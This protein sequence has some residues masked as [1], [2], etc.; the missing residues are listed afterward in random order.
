MASLRPTDASRR[1]WALQVVT[2]DGRRRTV[3]LALSELAAM[4]FKALLEALVCAADTGTELAPET[5]TQVGRLSEA[6][7]ARLADWGLLAEPKAVA[8]GDF[9]ADY[10]QRRRADAKPGTITVFGHTK[11]CLITCFGEN[12]PIRSLTAADGEDFRH[13]LQTV[14]GLAANTVNRRCGIA[15][16]FFHA[17]KRRG[18]VN[19]NPFAGLPT[20]VHRNPA[21]DR[22]ITPA[23]AARILDACPDA[24]W[25]TIFALCRWSGLRCPSEV[26]A[27]KWADIDWARGRLVV[28][29]VKTAHHAGRETRLCPLFPE[30]RAALMES[31]E[32]ADEGAVYVVPR[33]RSRGAKANLRTTFT[34]IVRRAGVK[35]WPKLFVNLRATRATELADEFPGHVVSAWLGHSEAIAD[36]H[37]RQVTD[38]HFE[39]AARC[40]CAAP[41]EHNGPFPGAEQLGTPHYGITSPD[42][43]KDWAR[44]DS[45]PRPSDYESPAL[46]T[47]LRA[48]DVSYLSV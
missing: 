14:E 33:L 21:R 44:R 32:L 35:P 1:R 26:A 11:R 46:T 6:M 22:F 40:N 23:E 41:Q 36:K 37:Y 47:E 15:R 4:R 7:R 30:V 2:P 12:R 19:S 48:L 27:L 18:L 17:A 25:R 31:F 10:I 42:S 24:E 5:M 43:S 45:N 3:R 20:T 8:L 16:Q 13:H 29:C 38:E 28:T 39:R 34:K 9:L